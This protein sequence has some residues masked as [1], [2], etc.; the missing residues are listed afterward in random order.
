MTTSP[1]LDLTLRIICIDPPDISDDPRAG[2]GV[3]DKSQ[4]IT[5]GDK[6]PDGSL[7]FTVSISVKGTPGIAS[8]NF[9]GSFVHGTPQQRFLYL[10]LGTQ[11]G[12]TWQWTRRIKVPLLGITWSQIE[13]AGSKDGLLE[14]SIDGTRSGTVPLLGEGWVVRE[15]S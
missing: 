8:P 4:Q 7:T 9:A 6:R 5:N 3:Q 11:K 14:V 12:S 1:T 2:F 15:H 13:E 10:S